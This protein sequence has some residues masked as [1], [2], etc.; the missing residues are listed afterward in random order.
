MD[1]QLETF[2]GSLAGRTLH[3]AEEVIDR[4]VHAPGETRLLCSGCHE[5]V[6]RNVPVRG[7][8][9]RVF[10]CARCGVLSVVGQTTIG[11]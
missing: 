7:I 3:R 10:E 4:A 11:A 1:F 5:V 2:D 9:R 6:A 8:L